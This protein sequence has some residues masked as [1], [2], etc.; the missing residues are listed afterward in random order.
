AGVTRESPG[1]HDV[2]DLLDREADLVVGVEE[3]RADPDPGTRTVVAE[4]AALLELRVDGPGFRHAEDHCT[5]SP[6]RVARA[7]N[8]EPHSVRVL[9]EKLRLPERALAD[10]VDADLL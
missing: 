9:D 1:L 3:V 4:D 8:L 5:A 2:C 7:Q 6:S 10:P